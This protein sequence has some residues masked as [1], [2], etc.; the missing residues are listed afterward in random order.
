MP[1]PRLRR[2]CAGDYACRD[3]FSAV[4]T[5]TGLDTYARDDAGQLIKSLRYLRQRHLQDS[6]SW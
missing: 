1:A 6:V 5:A 4:T 3:L 2:N